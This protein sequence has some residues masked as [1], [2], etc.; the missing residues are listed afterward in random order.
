MFRQQAGCHLSLRLLSCVFYL[1]RK[2][3]PSHSAV[4][5]VFVECQ[6]G[7]KPRPG[8]WTEVVRKTARMESFMHSWPQFPHHQKETFC[9]KLLE[10]PLSGS[11]CG[12][13]GC[14]HSSPVKPAVPQAP[15]TRESGRLVGDGSGCRLAGPA[16]WP[17]LTERGAWGLRP[18]LLITGAPCLAQ[19]CLT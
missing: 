19:G 2:V 9:P 17:G 4:L 3:A 15:G 8:K 16:S 11:I 10:V 14:E 1:L 13:L 6:P 18:A 5:T 7:T 12:V